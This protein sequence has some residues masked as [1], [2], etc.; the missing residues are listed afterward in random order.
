MPNVSKIYQHLLLNQTNDYFEGL[1][2]KYQ[3][4]F[5]QRLSAQ[6]SLIVMLKKRKTSVDKGKAFAALL[7]EL[8][9]LNGCKTLIYSYLSD[10]KQ[11]TKI[12]SACSSWEKFSLLFHRVIYLERCLLTFLSVIYSQLSIIDFASY[13]DDNTPNVIREIFQEVIETLENSSK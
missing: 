1:F 11:V 4:D 9:L 2:S 13:A 7:T 10:R 3:C 8:T 5:R 6:D 12:N